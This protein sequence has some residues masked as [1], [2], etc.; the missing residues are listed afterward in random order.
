MKVFIYYKNN[1]K[2]K[3]GNGKFAVFENV[4]KV[5]L[6]KENHKIEIYTDGCGVMVF[7]TRYFKTT[8]YQN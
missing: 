5:V 7:D 3:N 1:Y 2:N 4:D 8:I 6:D